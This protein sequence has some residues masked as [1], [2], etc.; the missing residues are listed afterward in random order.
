M[1]KNNFNHIKGDLPVSPVVK[2]LPS[3]RAATDLIPS[4]GAKIPH[5]WRARNQNTKQKHTAT[6]SIRLS[7]WA[8]S[9]KIFKVKKF[10]IKTRTHVKV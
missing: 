9:K 5:A 4:Q 10:K 6:N 2:T 7:K 1:K 3:N 8:T